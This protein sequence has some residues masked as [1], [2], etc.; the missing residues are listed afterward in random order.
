MAGSTVATVR[1]WLLYKFAEHP[2]LAG[3]AL[4]YAPPRSEELGHEFV[5]CGSVESAVDEIATIKSGRQRREEEY[6]MRWHVGVRGEGMD[7]AGSDARAVQLLAALEEVVADN[8]T[9]TGIGTATDQQ[10][11]EC[12]ADGWDSAEGPTEPGGYGFEYVLRVYVRARL[13]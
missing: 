11:I 12:R 7:P 5:M 4:H 1:A 2:D 6:V 9:L 3:V 10:I 13:L 8:G